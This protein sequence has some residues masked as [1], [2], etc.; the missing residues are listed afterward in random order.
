MFALPG[1]EKMMFLHLE[2]E[3]RVDEVQVSGGCA[4]KEGGGGGALKD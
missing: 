2:K 1:R 3:N 4:G